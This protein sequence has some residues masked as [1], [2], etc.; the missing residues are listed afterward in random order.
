MK[1][2]KI[3]REVA[4]Y[5]ALVSALFL[6]LSPQFLGYIFPILFLLPIYLGLTGIKN[7][8]K[9][10][11]YVGMGMVPLASSVAILWIRYVYSIRGDFEGEFL[12]V[13]DKFNISASTVRIITSISTVFSVVLLILAIIMFRKLTK[14]RK[15]FSK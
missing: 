14:N 8:K 4:F 3:V 11:Y 5:Y 10:G 7:R 2:A 6:G 9:V 1:E 13:A 15:V 12:A